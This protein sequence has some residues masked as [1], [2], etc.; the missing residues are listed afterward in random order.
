MKAPIC[1]VCANAGELCGSC[2]EKLEKGKITQADVKLA[3]GINEL[4]VDYPSLERA[5]YLSAGE[6]KNLL[7]IKVPRGTAGQI[8]GRRG[9]L[10]NALS[11]H[12]DKK[13]KVVEDASDTRKVI[14]KV[15]YPAK[16]LGLT[17][18]GDGGS[19]YKIRV[20]HFD[21]RKVGDKESYEALFSELLNGKAKIVFE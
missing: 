21:E 5:E 1:D 18:K 13:L 7:L 4:S 15:L 11:K 20:P 16:F 2:K 10:I 8:I 9:A 19:E 6:Y 14:E 12:L 3:R 17:V